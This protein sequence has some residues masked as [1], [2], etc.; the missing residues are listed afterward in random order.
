MK[1]I[2]TIEN[3]IYEVRGQRVMLDYDIAELYQVETK[4]LNQAVKRNIIR[5]PSDFMFR[6]SIAEWETMWSQIVTTLP[7]STKALR[8]QIATTAQNSRRKD[9]TPFAFTEHGVTML[10]S[11]LRSETA[12]K[13]NITIVRAFIAIRQYIVNTTNLNDKL[14]DLRNELKTR[15]DEHDTQLNAIYD[16]LETLLDKKQDEIEVKENWKN[17][18]RIGFKTG[19][20]N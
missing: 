9:N 1:I 17:R 4:V 6:L 8:S 12:I 11:V 13:M 10:A 2:Q 5:F 18:E 7:S 15:I 14:N 19:K 20:K 16:T 3:K